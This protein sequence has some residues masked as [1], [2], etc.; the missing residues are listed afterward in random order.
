ML[1][2]AYA[3]LF[4][5]FAIGV[6]I[7]IA[8]RIDLIDSPDIRKH[9][10]GS[11]PLVGGIAI[12]L[13]ILGYFL[14]FSSLN[15][16]NI[17]YLVGGG[18]IVS[19]GILDDLYDL[20]VRYRLLF[21]LICAVILI[22][23]TNNYF[24]N[25]GFLEKF[26]AIEIGSFGVLLTILYIIM[27]INSYNMIDGIDGLLGTVS[28]ISFVT[29]AILFYLSDSSLTII[30]LIISITI[31]T[32]L[33]FN[34]NV[35]RFIPQIF[36]GDS[37]AMFLGL[38]ISW[39]TLT[40]TIV[41]NS[42]N[43]IIILY[44]VAVPFI[45]LVFNIFNRLRKGQSPIRPARDHIHHRLMSR[46]YSN[47]QTLMIISALA[48]F[49]ALLGIAGAYYKIDDVTMFLGFLFIMISFS[50]YFIHTSKFISNE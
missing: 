41:E 17:T 38:T 19:I 9:H 44:I 1:A 21:Q 29:I 33:I 40:G 50:L 32:F 43:P 7:P 4:T 34:L 25:I 2:V 45:D 15:I 22:I 11:V 3:F 13:S 12:Y 6:L 39:L 23:F 36:M 24:D 47:G 35:F 16:E 42:F 14:L 49:I 26:G 10:I 5:F 31:L 8:K 48:I 46:G 37:G 30:P 27:N 20:K 28:L 18:I